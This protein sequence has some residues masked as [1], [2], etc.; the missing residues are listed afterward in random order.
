MLKYILCKGLDKVQVSK[1]VMETIA[2]NINNTTL[3]RLNSCLVSLGST[4]ASL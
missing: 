2:V 1:S 3:A 4:P